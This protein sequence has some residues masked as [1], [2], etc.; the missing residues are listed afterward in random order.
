MI[1]FVVIFKNHRHEKK[2]D[3]HCALFFLRNK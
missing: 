2:P 1:N 3:F